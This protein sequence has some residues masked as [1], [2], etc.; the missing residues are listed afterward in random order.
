M[1]KHLMLILLVLLSTNEAFGC[2]EIKPNYEI[3]QIVKRLAYPD[4]PQAADVFAIIRNESSYRPNVINRSGR[5]DSRGLMQVAKGPLNIRLNIAMGVS[6]LREYYM[7]THSRKGAVMSYNIG[8]GNYLKGRLKVSGNRYYSKFLLQRSVYEHYAKTGK[9]HY[10]GRY[11]GCTSRY[12]Y[13]SGERVHEYTHRRG[14]PSHWEAKYNHTSR[15]H[16]RES[17]TWQ[18]PKEISSAMDIRRKPCLLSWQ[19]SSSAHYSCS[20]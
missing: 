1:I 8:I 13:V 17:H 3:T 11:R 14:L 12:D 18:S 10:L 19:E 5:E 4:F 7:I 2:G 6:L 20:S 16:K 15:W 9:L